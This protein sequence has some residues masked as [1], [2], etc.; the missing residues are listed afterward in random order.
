MC[1]CV[2]GCARLPVSG[3]TIVCACIY[4]VCVCVPVCVCVCACCQGLSAELRARLSQ[5]CLDVDTVALYPGSIVQAAYQPT[6]LRSAL[7]QLGDVQVG[8]AP[9]SCNAC[10]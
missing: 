6:A 3:G 7:I 9:S 2:H 8:Y 4:Y 10:A 1:L 5:W